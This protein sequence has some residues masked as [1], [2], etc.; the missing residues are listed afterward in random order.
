MSQEAV[1]SKVSKSDAMHLRLDVLWRSLKRMDYASATINLNKDT[2]YHI[3]GSSEAY[4]DG[5]IHAHES[6][7]LWRSIPIR[8]RFERP[9]TAFHGDAEISAEPILELFC[10]YI[11]VEKR[12]GRHVY[13]DD[14][15]TDKQFL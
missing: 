2:Y 3:F 4:V 14:P 15:Q 1:E 11:D 8:L 7:Q 12:N 5:S 10:M 6:G 9:L 13:I